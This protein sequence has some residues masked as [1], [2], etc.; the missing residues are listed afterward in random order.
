MSDKNLLRILTLFDTSEEAESIINILRNAGQIIRDI[1]VEDEEDLQNALNENPVDIVLAKQ[2]TP[3][4][5]A[6]EAVEFLA[7]NGRDLPLVVITP[8]GSPADAKEELEAGARDAV[9]S[10]QAHRIKHIVKREI[11]DLKIRRAF[12]RNEQMLL[13]NEKRTRYLIDQSR[14]AI[15]YVHDGMHLYANNAYLKMFGY[16]DLDDIE[17]VPILDM[18]TS[19]DHSTLKEFLRKYAKGQN[20]DDTL[21]VEGKHID[22]NAF[23]ITMEF[24][25]ASMEG[26][27][28]SQIII[29][30]QSNS[31]ELE[32]QLHMLS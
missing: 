5:S 13:E 17:G 30:D 16:D 7:T 31:K 25:R 18:V 24:S 11:D 26:E 3:I 29:R 6:K 23:N 19:E 2:K 15:A 28:C 21:E 22:G 12:R 14:D 9:A 4:Y 27:S 1:R 8:A 10:D 32:K 20:T